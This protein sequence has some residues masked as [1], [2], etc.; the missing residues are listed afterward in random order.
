MDDTTI[1]VSSLQPPF[2]ACHQCVYFVDKNEDD[3]DDQYFYNRMTTAPLCS[4]AWNSKKTCDAK[5][6]RLGNQGN[7]WNTADQTLLVFFSFFGTYCL[8]SAIFFYGI[9]V[10]FEGI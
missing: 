2:K 7:T 9:D 4:G 5:C 10:E 6:R 3:V 8:Y 1:D